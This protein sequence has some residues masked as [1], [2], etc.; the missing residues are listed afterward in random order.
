MEKNQI[1]QEL[2]QQVRWEMD[3]SGTKP[4]GTR[5]FPDRPLTETV[6][7]KEVA[8][9]ILLLEN[10]VFLNSHWWMA[11]EGWPEAAC[12]RPSLNVDTS[13]VLAWAV[14]DAYTM[15][16][17]DIQEVYEHWERDPVWGTA[18]WYCKKEGMM[19]Q[20]LAAKEIRQ[21]GI[22]DIDSMGL[23]PNPAQRD[24]KS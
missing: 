22:W 10:V 7:E 21:A 1:T 2:Q 5:Q 13:D 17:Q 14:A 19:P 24:Q 9:A 3:W 16:Y 18:V 8:L 11:A 6:F 12:W 4:D 15:D 23:A 20:P